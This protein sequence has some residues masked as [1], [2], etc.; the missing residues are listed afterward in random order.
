[1][2]SPINPTIP[3]VITLTAKSKKAKESQLNRLRNAF[4][5]VD[6]FTKVY[7][8]RDFER[9]MT[10]GG[11]G[12]KKADWFI[13]ELDEDDENVQSQ[14]QEFMTKKWVYLTITNPVGHP[15]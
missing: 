8:I 7:K 10:S 14:F 12:L 9:K 15:V 2:P 6:S 5:L 3:N 1:M 11:S 13:D 4:Q